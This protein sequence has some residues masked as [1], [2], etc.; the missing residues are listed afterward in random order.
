LFRCFFSPDIYS[1]INTI[2]K[3]H[4]IAETQ[5]AISDLRAKRVFVNI[6][7]QPDRPRVVIS[8]LIISKLLKL[9]PEL[10]YIHYKHRFFLDRHRILFS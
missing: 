6:W 8:D 4:I 9:K 5:V 1:D 3:Y 7:I 10:L 2:V